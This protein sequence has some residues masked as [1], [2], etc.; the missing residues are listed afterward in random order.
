MAD[1]PTRM[2]REQVLGAL[3]PPVAD[4]LLPAIRKAVR[5]SGRKLVVIDDDPTGCQTVHD[6][7]VLCDWSVESLAAE[8]AGEYPAFYILTNSRGLP[9]AEAQALTLDV[10][11]NLARAAA[12]T[13]QDFAVVSRS[14]ST[15][16]GHFPGEVE[17][18]AEGLTDP[19]HAWILIPFF[20]EG[21][22]YT[23]ADVH[24]VDEVGC[25]VPAG[26]TAFARDPAFAFK[27]SN[28]R[29]WVE[30]KTAGRV[31]ADDV[32][33]ISIEDLRQGGPERVSALLNALPCKAVCVVNAA[34]MRDLE[35][36]SLGLLAA[37]A[38]GK[39]FLC[40]TAA[41]FVPARIGLE[42]RP[43]L[44]STELELG[45]GGGLMMVGSHVPKTTA[46]LETLLASWPCR[47]LEVDV[48]QLLQEAHR[49]AEIQRVAR[50]AGEALKAGEDVVIYTGRMLHKVAGKEA[51]LNISQ[52]VS[53]GL[54]AI[55]RGINTRPRYLVAKGGITS[56]DLATRALEVTRALVPGQ[57]LPGVP[58][59][60]LGPESRFPGLP[61]VVFPGN[62]GDEDGLLAIARKLRKE[63]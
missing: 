25:F 11:E 52:R 45:S 17:A 55:L 16:R 39:R 47:T 21:G 56:S 13:G 34:H 41:S 33:S 54:V 44:E 3:P 4:D 14:D 8:L 62:V 19:F 30:E 36:F 50:A 37:E 9:L 24:Y 1:E 32:V 28:L 59:W 31:T 42:P 10:A 43:L 20:L 53:A 22:R 26:E 5:A 6:L 38:G 35:V 29:T 49:E 48:E 12:R 46:Q 57:I 51:N 18:L 61:Y 58:V 15:L 40:R 7:P 60:N 2:S 23:V 27:A 63:P